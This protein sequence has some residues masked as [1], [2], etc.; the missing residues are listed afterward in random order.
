[1]GVHHHAKAAA[2]FGLAVDEKAAVEAVRAAK[3]ERQRSSVG[4]QDRPAYD[5]ACRFIFVGSTDVAGLLGEVLED[6]APGP[7]SAMPG[8]RGQVLATLRATPRD[9]T[10]TSE[11]GGPACSVSRK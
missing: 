5:T 8:S 6:G 10:S 7:D 2:G 9:G 4:G 1:M 11:K 3:V